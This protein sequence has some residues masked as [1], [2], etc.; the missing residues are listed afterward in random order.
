MLH[1]VTEHGNRLGP[2][3]VFQSLSE[4]AHEYPIVASSV[5]L[6]EGAKCFEQRRL[7]LVRVQHAGNM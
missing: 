6:L 5:L 3:A 4:G 7:N 1:E 2:A